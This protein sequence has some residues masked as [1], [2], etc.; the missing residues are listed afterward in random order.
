VRD[1][2]AY[3]TE[4]WRKVTRKVRDIEGDGLTR[5][6]QGYDPAHPFID[7]LKRKSHFSHTAFSEADV[8]SPRFP[9]RCAEACRA[10]APLM[11]FLTEAVDLDW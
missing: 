5:P 6:P 7:D 2:I 11:Q 3:D 10:K 9:A 8:C 1:A 4:G